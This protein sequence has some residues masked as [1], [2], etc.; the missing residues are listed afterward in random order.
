MQQDGS[1][2]PAKFISGMAD[3]AGRFFSTQTRDFMYLTL[4]E[5]RFVP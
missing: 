5:T 3:N 2:K 4:D 1:M